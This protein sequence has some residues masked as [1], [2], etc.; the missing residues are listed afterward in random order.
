[1][2]EPVVIKATLDISGLKAGAEQA[3]AALDKMGQEA[4]R[5]AKALDAMEAQAEQAAAAAAKIKPLPASAATASRLPAASGKSSGGNFG[6]GLD[7]EL[8]K[9]ES[10]NAAMADLGG[11]GSEG[12]LKASRA[13][14][15]IAPA[16]EGSLAALGS[17][18]GPLAAV[19]AAAAAIAATVGAMNALAESAIN[20]VKAQQDMADS[21]GITVTQ[22]QA[23]TAGADDFGIGP[24]KMTESLA[25]L[26]IMMG[27]AANGSKEA[28]A[29]LSKLGITSA[30]DTYSA[31]LKIAD[32]TAAAGSASEKVAIASDLFGRGSAQLIP[33]LNQGAAGLDA[34]QA[35]ALATGQAL[36]PD[37]V[38][39]ALAAWSNLDAAGDQVA[40]T[41]QNI[42]L[43]MAPVAEA[44][45]AVTQVI[46]EFG[47]SGESINAVRQVSVLAGQA[48]IYM[49]RVGL[50]AISAISGALGIVSKDMEA[51]SR[52]TA[53]ASL[54]LAAVS[55][56]LDEPAGKADAVANAVGGIAEEAWKAADAVSDL[57]DEIDSLASKRAAYLAAQDK[58]KGFAAEMRRE[59]QERV[60]G[61]AGQQ[62]LKAAGADQEKA[63]AALR[64]ATAAAATAKAEKAFK[65][66][67][68]SGIGI[69]AAGNAVNRARFAEDAVKRAEEAA[70]IKRNSEAR[71]EDISTK[72]RQEANVIDSAKGKL[73]SGMLSDQEAKAY[74]EQI[75]L[76][77]AAIKRLEEARRKNAAVTDLELK[78][79]ALKQGPEYEKKKAEAKAEKVDTTPTR[80]TASAVIAGTVEALRLERGGP[81]DKPELKFLDR[82]AKAVEKNQNPNLATA[83]F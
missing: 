41:M 35:S 15:S 45:A 11:K 77:T 31:L 22:M 43:A 68:E 10:L 67:Q 49:A 60:T 14:A 81:A 32:A 78:A 62:A 2:A 26:N 4:A 16:A 29:S 80:G 7:D 76:S 52:K 17:L 63:A 1:M 58:G 83:N 18:A 36:S 51:L 65:A 72:I 61:D 75:E 59:T 19:G 30:D 37:Q 50:D 13:V 24:E 82:I 42:K 34:M 71:D 79:A 73:S 38:N 8:A 23:L 28:Q 74:R 5:T 6:A 39:A 40:G 33:L 44:V 25:K 48:L 46:A 12:G 57:G 70:A 20:G 54:S 27:E 53:A 3:S 47:S 21:I 9:I 55:D 69:D 64:L 56:K 66:A